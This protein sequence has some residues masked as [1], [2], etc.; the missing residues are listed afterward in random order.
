MSSTSFNPHLD[1]LATRLFDNKVRPVPPL[2]CPSA[3]ASHLLIILQTSN[4]SAQPNPELKVLSASTELAYTPT[5]V[6]L[7]L[8]LCS[9]LVGGMR[10]GDR[11]AHC[12]PDRIR[13]L[14]GSVIW[15]HRNN[16]PV[17]AHTSAEDIIA[18]QLLCVKQDP[19]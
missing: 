12:V 8:D 6:S 7:G 16:K 19:L 11:W 18:A 4:F 15:V 1:L 14:A 2:S 9:A 3:A 17:D 10:F 5:V 13:L